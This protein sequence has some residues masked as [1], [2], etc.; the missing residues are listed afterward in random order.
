MASAMDDYNATALE[1]FALE[2]R[3]GQSS[4]CVP[5]TPPGALFADEPQVGRAPRAEMRPLRT[6]QDKMEDAPELFRYYRDEPD[7]PPYR[8]ELSKAKFQQ[9]R[10]KNKKRSVKRAAAAS[11]DE[12]LGG[13]KSCSIKHQGHLLGPSGSE[14][15]GTTNPLNQHSHGPIYTSWTLDRS[16]LPLAYS[17]QIGRLLPVTEEDRQRVGLEDLPKHGLTVQEWDGRRVWTV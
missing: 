14:G 2:G 9:K 6:L 10:H 13:T 16:K 3:L 8:V 4:A 17:S 7:A 1:D 5:D 15:S 12:V 11:K